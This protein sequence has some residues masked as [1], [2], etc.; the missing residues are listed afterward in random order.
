MKIINKFKKSLN[1]VITTAF[2]G[3]QLA[4]PLAVVTAFT[5]K[6]GATKPDDLHK[7]TI[8]H[9][10]NSTTNPYVQNDVDEASVDGDSGND[11]GQGDHLMEHTGPVWDANT[12]YPAPHNGDQ[13]GDIIPP[14][15]NDGVTLTGYP[16]LNWDA[17]GQAIFYNGCAPVT[18]VTALVTFNDDCGTA[19]D[20]YTIV[21]KDHVSYENTSTG[22]PVTPTTYPGIGAVSITAVADQ[23][24]T[25][26]GQ[27]V[28][29]HTFSTATCEEPTPAEPTVVAE[30]EGCVEKGDSDGSVTVTVTNTD[31]DTDVAVT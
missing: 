12:I 16:S 31:D 8:C 11:K 19:S 28:F 26:T 4:A 30:S 29:E 2:L 27:E 25:L 3:V 14:F 18:N 22:D 10:T 6:A 15:Y 9:R 7:V 21:A 13:W 5:A 17:A 1:A 20:T 24:Y 23:G